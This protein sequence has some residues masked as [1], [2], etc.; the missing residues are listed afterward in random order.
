[1]LVFASCSGHSQ[2]TLTM[3][4]QNIEIAKLAK[5]EASML[6]NYTTKPMYYLQVNKSACRVLVRCNDIPLGY[7]FVED[8]GES[9]LYPINYRLLSSGS[10][11]FSIHVYPMKNKEYLTKDAWVDVKVVYLPH[12]DSALSTAQVLGDALGLPEDIEEQRLPYYSASGTFDATLPFDYSARLSKARDLRKIPNLEELVVAKYNAIR[13]QMVDCKG[14]E[15][16]KERI[17]YTYPN[18]DMV[19][20]NE[21]DIK[22]ATT[23]DDCFNPDLLGREVAPLDN[24]EMVICGKGKIVYLRTKADLD[25]VLMVKWYESEKHQQAD[26]FAISTTA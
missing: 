4:Q 22:L 17:Q 18:S 20:L 19:Y 24:Y 23:D 13:Q 10:H 15:F 12:K 8:G 5:Q 9:M 7:S 14:V 3:E 25:D 2:N 16:T 1:M 21:E 11:T 26:A 6:K